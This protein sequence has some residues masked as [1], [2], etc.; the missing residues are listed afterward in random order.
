[1]KNKL[2]VFLILVLAALFGSHAFAGVLMSVK[3]AP[4]IIAVFD[5]PPVGGR[6]PVATE[7]SVVHSA[8]GV[9]FRS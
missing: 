2:T 4:P 1:M 3:V 8:R 6:K 7:K 9:L 5:Q